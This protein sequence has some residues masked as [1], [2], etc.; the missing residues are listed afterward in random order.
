MATTISPQSPVRPRRRR[1]W[2]RWTL[3]GIV[4]ALVLLVGAVALA[5][6]MQPVPAPLRLPASVAA[7]VGSLDGTYQAGPGS[8]A[9]FRVQQTVVGLTSEVVGRTGDVTG[10]V[11][12]AGGQVTTASL[13]VNLLALTSGG[14]PGAKPAPQFGISLATQRYPDATIDL[15]GPVTLGGSLASGT[16][17]RVTATGN[18]T[19]HG[20]TRTVTVPLTIRRDAADLEVTGSFPV[21]FADWGIAQP[22]GYGALGSLA[23]HGV[24]E[25]L[26][27]LRHA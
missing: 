11:A 26:L 21:V 4:A 27:I 23:D 9:G 12:V 19:M 24:A 1:H 14:N 8:V 5:V 16:A 6:R 25:F 17:V 20:V 10:S 3:V 2:L 13:R 15:A 7:P 22:K 18:L